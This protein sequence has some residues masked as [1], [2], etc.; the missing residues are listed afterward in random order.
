MT[1]ASLST[2][3][4]HL[5]GAVVDPSDATYDATRRI[6]NGSIDRR[7]EVILRCAGAADVI[8]ALA[9]AR[10]SDRPF[11]IRGGGHNVAG[12]SVCDGGVMIDLSM[13]KSIRVDPF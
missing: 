10:E 3:R 5:R 4:A 11:S 12:R 13:M 2:L 8:H 7:P 1:S 9:H 6:Y